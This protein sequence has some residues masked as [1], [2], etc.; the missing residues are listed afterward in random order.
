MTTI[1]LVLCCSIIY[2]SDV[3]GASKKSIEKEIDRLD[4]LA[5]STITTHKVVP[6]ETTTKAPNLSSTIKTSISNKTNKT[7]TTVT[8][9]TT[10]STTEAPKT[11]T[12]IISVPVS[13]PK[14]YKWIV[15]GTNSTIIIKMA[16]RLVILYQNSTSKQNLSVE[17]DVP[18]NNQ[19][20]V[21]GSF[22]PTDEIFTLS[23]NSTGDNPNYVQFHFK[24]LMNSYMLNNLEVSLDAKDVPESNSRLVLIHKYEHF[25]VS[26]GNSYR[27]V[28]LQTFNLTREN[29]TAIAGY[30]KVTDLQLQ[31]F[32]SDRKA[33]F[34]YA[35]DCAFDTPDV[36]PIAVG[37]VLA[38]LVIIVLAAYL[39]S[40]KRN[41]S[42]GYLSM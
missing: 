8:N 28:R 13:E 16:I 31:A 12:K 34:G 40:R 20:Q 9:N 36:V 42:R 2:A 3:S 24:R 26:I 21:N 23:W 39:I 5:S 10:T 4:A 25:N 18:A 27:C 22:T 1:A 11:K 29:D 14:P 32:K 33:S 6:T 19:T 35:E 41:E 15:N 30:M 17:I 37:C 7:A 38:G